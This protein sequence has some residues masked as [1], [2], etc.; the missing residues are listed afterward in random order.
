MGTQCKFIN[1]KQRFF[2]DAMF[3]S[4]GVIEENE[5]LTNSTDE[6]VLLSETI[7]GNT[8]NNTAMNFK[9]WLAGTISSDGTD[10]CV[11]TLRYG[12]T[13]ILALTTVSLPNEDDKNFLLE[14]WGRVHTTG[15]TGKVV[16]TG[17]FVTDMTGIADIIGGTVVAGATVD[18]T[19]DGSLNITADWDDGSADTE[20]NVTSGAIQ[21]FS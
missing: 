9:A 21:L 15:A 11:F 20:V 12:S 17:K 6:T 4:A 7:Y 14:F 1:G 18:L 8:L 2:S 13:D 3:V 5:L 16:A 10:D 19:A